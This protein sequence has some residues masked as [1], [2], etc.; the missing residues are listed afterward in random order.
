VT[1]RRQHALGSVAAAPALRALLVTV[2]LW[3]LRTTAATVPASEFSSQREGQRLLRSIDQG[4]DEC[5]D[6]SDGNSS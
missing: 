1:T 4:S 2:S 6:L 5:S 3:A